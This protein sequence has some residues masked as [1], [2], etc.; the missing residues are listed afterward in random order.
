MSENQPK[1]KESYEQN[2]KVSGNHFHGHKN[3]F[4]KVICRIQLP[5]DNLTVILI[6]F[7]AKITSIA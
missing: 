7:E 1:S 4:A 6:E 3:V 2:D 5:P